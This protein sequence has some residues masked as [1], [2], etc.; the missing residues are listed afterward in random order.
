MTYETQSASELLARALLRLSDVSS[1]TGDDLRY[2]RQALGLSL[3]D[4][5]KHLGYS[6]EHLEKL[7]ACKFACGFTRRALLEMLV[8]RISNETGARE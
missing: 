5:A 2:A 6:D 8:R 3:S 4:A 1:V 7:E